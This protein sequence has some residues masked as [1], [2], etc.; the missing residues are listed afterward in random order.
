MNRPRSIDLTQVC[1]WEE[2]RL[3]RF[4]DYLVGEEPLEIRVGKYP[5]SVA[6]R[7]PGQDLELTAGFLFTEGLIQRR[8]Q[9]LPLEQAVTS[10]ERARG[11]VVQV[12][13]AGEA[14]LNLE[15]TQRNFFAASSCG[16]CGK[17][18]IDS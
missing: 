9:I 10:G 5:L 14:A 3:R 13:M 16:I 1:E 18:S 12:E 2:G 6:M 8:D 17:A 15:Q 7:T 4:Q 11:N